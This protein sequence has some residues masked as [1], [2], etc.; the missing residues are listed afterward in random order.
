[1]NK[2]QRMPGFIIFAVIAMATLLVAE[3]FID[4][5]VPNGRR[6][7][8]I[9]AEKY[10][11]GNVYIGG[12][13]GWGKRP[14]GS[15]VTID[16]EFSYVTPENDFKQAMINPKPGVWKWENA[17]NWVKHC[18]EMKQVVRM[19][20]PISPQASKWAQEDS[21]TPEELENC[22]TEFMTKLCLRY[23]KYPHVKWLDVVNETVLDNGKWFGPKPGVD[24][25]QN[26]WPIIG[27]DQSDPLKPP[28]YIKLAFEI[29]TKHAPNTKLIIN[30]HGGMNDK[31]WK[32][33]KALV[34]YLRKNGCR[35]D[36]IGWQAHVDVGWEKKANNMKKLGELIDWA[37]ANELSF[38]ITE[39][40]IWL[41]GEKKDYE[42]QAVSFAAIMRTLLEKRHSGVVT[43]NVWNLSDGDAW[44]EMEQY[45]GCLFERG[46]T[47]KP[48]YY[49]IQD[50]LENPPK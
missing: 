30:Q 49:A 21:R 34:I 10:P 37:H 47:V 44:P 36:G 22:M 41:K 40:N 35:V 27:F 3:G 9:V 32:K 28:K 17:D 24:E 19:H 48:A 33:I 39:N 15:G 23:D 6:I 11:D 38:H 7:R 14:G 12:T 45:D 13:T 8:K 25:W 29:A 50:V 26:P 20:G 4:I 43:W 42:A 1:M 2:R 5:P 16:R 46:Y 31:A 18:A